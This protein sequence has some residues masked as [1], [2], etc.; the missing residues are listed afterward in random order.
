[1]TVGTGKENMHWVGSTSEC[2]TNSTH[3]IMS[4]ERHTLT[5]GVA[6]ML[7]NELWRDLGHTE[8]EKTDLFQTLIAQKGELGQGT[9]PKS[10]MYSRTKIYHQILK[11]N[12]PLEAIM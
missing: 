6:N 10:A 5:A 2:N 1:M 12:K 4:K 11:H 7:L 3:P 8:Q 9:I